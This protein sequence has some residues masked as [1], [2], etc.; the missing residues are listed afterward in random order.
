MIDV[1]VCVFVAPLRVEQRYLQPS[2]VLS[3][4]WLLP[5]LWRVVA[6]YCAQPGMKATPSKSCIIS[7]SVLTCTHRIVL[8][9]G[10]LTTI[11][12][13]KAIQGTLCGIACTPSGVL[14]L[15][16]PFG[17]RIY[18]VDPATGRWELLSGPSKGEPTDGPALSA[19][20]HSP[21]GIEV[22]AS[23][24]CA[25]VCDSGNHCIRRITLPPEWFVPRKH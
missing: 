20:F 16:D 1:R 3:T 12:F 19:V 8:I 25:Y 6:E 2:G 23:E 4:D 11:W 9:L 17:G 5:P 18:A 21:S 14:V 24:C 13:D 7:H 10:Q 15:T 22:V